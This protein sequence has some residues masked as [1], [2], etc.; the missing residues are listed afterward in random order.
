ML[1]ELQHDALNQTSK[2]V[3]SEELSTTLLIITCH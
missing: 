3:A 1:L 2:T